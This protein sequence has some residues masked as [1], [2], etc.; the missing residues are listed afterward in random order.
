[1]RIYGIRHWIKQS[2]KPVKD[3]LGWAGFQ[4]RSDMAIRLHQAQVNCAICFCWAPVR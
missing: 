2:C 3:Q 1:M 4:V